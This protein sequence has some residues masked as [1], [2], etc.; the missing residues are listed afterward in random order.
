MFQACFLLF[1]YVEIEKLE[2][3]IHTAVVTAERI[4]GQEKRLC[5]T[6]PS[7]NTVQHTF[8]TTEIQRCATT[9]NVSKLFKFVKCVFFIKVENVPKREL[10]RIERLAGLKGAVYLDADRH[11]F[12]R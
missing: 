7:A 9:C 5:H 1:F 2:L 12:G 6:T 3:A 10:R 8:L 11:F 4:S